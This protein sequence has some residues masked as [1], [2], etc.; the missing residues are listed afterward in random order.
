M[1][2]NKKHSPLKNRPLRN[3][4]Q[5][6]DEEIQDILSDDVYPHIF[7][8]AI[9]IIIAVMEWSKQIYNTPPYPLLWT[10]IALVVF[11]YY[12]IKSIKTWK[13]IKNVKLG[14]DGEKIMGQNLEQLR[15]TGYQV[16]HDMVDVDG[17]FNI[18]HIVIGPAGVFTVEIKTVSKR[19][20]EQK[21]ECDGNNVK[22]DGFVPDRNPIFQA[23][24]QAHWLEYF[25][26]ESVGMKINVKPVVVYPGWFVAPQPKNADVWVLNEKALPKFLQNEKV[27]IDEKE[28]NL[29]SAQI[30]RYIREIY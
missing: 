15:R 4:G 28:I 29:I 11:G 26:L 24:A 14:R 6:L 27:T 20:G 18:D 2:K 22:I 16:F 23:K 9:L 10:F 1:T 17:G 7:I 25:I 5:S 19:G 13:T 12:S 8:S 3:S 30:E 21:I